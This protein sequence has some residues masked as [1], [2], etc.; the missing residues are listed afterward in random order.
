MASVEIQLLGRFEVMVGGRP[1]PAP[2]W[3]H[4]RAAG[5]VKLLALAS[6]HRV[7]RE[8]VIEALWPHLPPVGGERNLHKAIHLARRG[9]GDPSAITLSS[10]EVG[11][12]G[13]VAVDVDRFEREA[14]LALGS[15]GQGG[16]ALAAS[17]YAGELLRE[18]RYEEWTQPARERLCL[19]YL[20]LLRCAERWGDVLE[21]EP[22]DEEAHRALMRPT[23]MPGTAQRPC[24]SSGAARICSGKSSGFGP[25]PSR[26]PC[27]RRL[28]GDPRPWR[29]SSPR[30]P[31]WAGRVS[32][33]RPW[34]RLGASTPGAA[35]VCW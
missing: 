22:L 14:E 5:L 12:G 10:R 23:P 16:C 4:R 8:Q 33:R 26:W 9:I 25:T 15:P 19:L 21:V 13:D 1:V 2:A 18:D 20:G 34:R 24:G 35:A 17:L 29:R 28:C 6:G 3:R 27:T 30:R 7:H 11:L 31:W 32:W